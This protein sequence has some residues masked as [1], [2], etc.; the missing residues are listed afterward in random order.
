LTIL[1]TKEKSPPSPAMILEERLRRE[2]KGR[3]L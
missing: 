1:Y 3:T 2:W